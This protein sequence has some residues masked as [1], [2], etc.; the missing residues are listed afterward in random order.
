MATTDLSLSGAAKLHGQLSLLLATRMPLGHGAFS[1]EPVRYSKAAWTTLMKQ[2]SLCAV[3]L[4]RV[5]KQDVD[6]QNTF[7]P[8]YVPVVTMRN[9]ANCWVIV[10]CRDVT[11]EPVNEF[12][13]LR[14]SWACQLCLILLRP[15]PHLHAS[16]NA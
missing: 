14:Q 1:F 3:Q 16:C 13:H 4:D 8:L 6:K 11:F 9:A 10:I 12:H 5:S 2:F 15:A 7:L